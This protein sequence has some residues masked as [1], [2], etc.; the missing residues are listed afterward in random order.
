M[1]HGER[2]IWGA[3]DLPVLKHGPRT[4][5]G[6]R[7]GLQE[8]R[9]RCDWTRRDDGRAELGNSV[10][11]GI[12][13]SVGASDHWEIFYAVTLP[14]RTRH[15][16]SGDTAITCRPAG[17]EAMSPRWG[18][19]ARFHARVDPGICMPGYTIGVARRLS[20]ALRRGVCQRSRQGSR[21][22]SSHGSWLPRTKRSHSA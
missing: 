21:E 7:A 22:A 6:P 2:E 17:P 9:E 8:T 12:G 16:E 10:V 3:V 18:W 19:G 20:T 13:A 11:I 4:E 14:L 5:E 15:G 1:P